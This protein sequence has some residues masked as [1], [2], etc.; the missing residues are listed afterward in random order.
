[1][2]NVYRAVVSGAV[3][4]LV[5]LS[6]AARATQAPPPQQPPA[7][8]P[9]APA[10]AA[11]SDEPAEY[12]VA[13]GDVL[14]IAVWKEPELTGDVF[15]RLDGRI[16]VPLVGDVIAAGRTTD[17]LAIEIRNKL[18]AFLETPQVTVTVTQ[19]VSARFYVIGEVVTSGAFP[20]TGR[21]SVLQ[22]LALA[23][24]FREFAKKDRILIIRDRRGQRSAIPFNFRDLEIGVNLEQ[25]VV[26]DAGDV[27]IVP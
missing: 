7:A 16:T 8:A 20:L 2:V 11:A 4:L 23:G 1:V 21:I 10:A 6:A 18:R 5:S 3:A 26:L 13:P 24:G 15:V 14:R 17:Y 12:Y 19:A 27:I 25:N 22:A 9:P